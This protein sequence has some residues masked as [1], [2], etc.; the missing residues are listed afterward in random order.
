MDDVTALPR[1]L[2]EICLALDSNLGDRL[3]YLC[4]AREAMAPYVTVTQS[5]AVYEKQLAYKSDQPLFL[6]AVVRGTTKLEPMALLYTLKHIEIDLGRKPTFRYGPRVIDIDI[7]FYGDVQMRTNDL[8]IPH[9]L[10]LERDY[11]LFPLADIAPDWVHPTEGKTVAELV[12]A[13]P[14]EEA[15]V[16]RVA[17]SF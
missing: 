10:M 1:P 17:E 6:N 15:T 7:L 8:T 9:A 2:V 12:Q 13:M 16:V 11:E 4:A 14:P 5:S 3:A